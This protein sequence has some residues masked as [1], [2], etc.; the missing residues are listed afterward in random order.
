M[1]GETSAKVCNR[2]ST[3]TMAINNT[4]RSIQA[5]S[6]DPS[7]LSEVMMKLLGVHKVFQVMYGKF[8]HITKQLIFGWS[9]K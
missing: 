4:I 7:D 8:P 2:L 1:G 5:V 3:E 9:A 6:T